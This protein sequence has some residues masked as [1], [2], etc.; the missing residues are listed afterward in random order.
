MYV[1][2]YLEMHTTLIGWLLYDVGWQ[3]LS[4]TGLIILPFLWILFRNWKDATTGLNEMNRTTHNDAKQ[5]IHD[6]LVGIGVLLLAMVPV[7]PLQPTTISY[8]P[9]PTFSNP[10]PTTA[11]A[12]TDPTTY[13][14]SLGDISNSS[15]VA[16]VPIWWRFIM[17]VS[18]G[19][20]HAVVQSLP[21][22][23]DLRQARVMI[24][25]S[26]IE[27]PTLSHEYQ[28]FIN[29]CYI[30]AHAR[31]RQYA[32]EGRLLNLD[33][34][35][36]DD[37]DWPGSRYLLQMP[38]GYAACPDGQ[39]N[40]CGSTNRPPPN[41]ASGLDPNT[42]TCGDWWL[43]IEQKIYDADSANDNLWAQLRTHI[44]GWTAT[45]DEVRQ[46]RVKSVLNNFRATQISPE[47]QHGERGLAGSLWGVFE[48]VAG[49][50]ALAWESV[51][52]EGILNIV[53]QAI[54]M[55]IAILLMF[56][57]FMIPFALVFTAY[58]LEAVIA[59]SFVIFS[60]TFVHALQAIASWLDYYLMTSLFSD[61]G[62]MS[63]LSG[64]AGH[65]LGTAQKRLL[66]NI[67]LAGAY[68]LVPMVWMYVMM[69]VGVGAA[70]GAGRMSRDS[71]SDP[72]V[73]AST[74]GLG[75]AY[76]AG[77]RAV[78]SSAATAVRTTTR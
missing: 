59:M 7:V 63:W 75:K 51:K 23:G 53:K 67:I 55:L 33:N 31:F 22:P 9:T 27:D 77:G 76:G 47:Y 8:E 43:Q 50:G 25:S 24:S 49:T 2:S 28:S 32:A 18:T 29:N 15:G 54:P 20:T 70:N 42:T 69:L 21:T 41:N 73:N 11:T 64:D 26:N 17:G 12:A 68:L 71:S 3:V 38:G 45:E 10:N 72:G 1:S 19:I 57:Y 37:V 4:Q 44:S 62:L 56:V 13:N 14:E 30:P 74:G 78:S 39:V 46:N 58:R 35:A 6:V 61:F 65:I 48:D 5:N 40:Q 66:I 36:P 16:Y 60:L 52:R 34:V